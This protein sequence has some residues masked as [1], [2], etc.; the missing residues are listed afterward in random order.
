M[1]ALTGVTA[2]VIGAVALTLLVIELTGDGINGAIVV[3]TA[4]ASFG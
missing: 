3:V 1:N 2:A 4:Y